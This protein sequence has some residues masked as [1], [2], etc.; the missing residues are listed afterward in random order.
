MQNT[1]HLKS[2]KAFKA[3][4]DNLRMF[5][6]EWIDASYVWSAWINSG[7][8]SWKRFVREVAA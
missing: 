5:S 4:F 8:I 1:T 2:A 6:P 7:R 3:Y